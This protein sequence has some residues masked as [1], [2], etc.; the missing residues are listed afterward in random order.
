MGGCCMR[1]AVLAVG[2]GLAIAGCDS[3]GLVFDD[4]DYAQCKQQAAKEHDLLRQH[5]QPLL[6]PAA[7]HSIEYLDGC[8][9][10]FDSAYMQWSFTSKERLGADR[11][12]AAGWTRVEQADE[13]AEP[14]GVELKLSQDGRP[15][16]TV[17]LSPE[18]GAGYAAVD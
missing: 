16:M 14:D 5:V 9:S 6:D 4:S 1:F 17:T 11:F 7:A 13:F 2:V 8:D 10:V 12:L 18:D 3:G 15:H